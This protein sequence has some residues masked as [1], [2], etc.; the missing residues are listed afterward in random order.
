MHMDKANMQGLAE[1]SSCYMLTTTAPGMHTHFSIIQ[2][3][4]KQTFPFP[5]KAPTLIQAEAESLELGG[6]GG[7]ARQTGLWV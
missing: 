2:S 7:G 4:Y 1:G 5:E 6:G 3:L